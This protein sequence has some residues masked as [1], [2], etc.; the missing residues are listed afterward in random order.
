M[1][2]TVLLL[3]AVLMTTFVANAQITEVEESEVLS[4]VSLLGDLIG[5]LN[6]VPN[7]DT[8]FVS[9]KDF[10][11]TTL[12]DHK[13]FTIGNKETVLQFKNIMLDMIKNKIKEKTIKLEGNTIEFVKRS[14]TIETFIVNKAGVVSK[15]RWMNKKHINKLFPADKLK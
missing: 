4:K 12:T 11:F 14:N 10:K 5:E 6:K 7:Q 2:K 13:S 15:M 8:Y 3:L 9:Y 1:K